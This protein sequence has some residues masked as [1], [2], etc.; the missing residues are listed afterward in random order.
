MLGES[1]RSKSSYGSSRV[2]CQ[3]RSYG[4]TPLWFRLNCRVAEYTGAYD[5]TA[6]KNWNI[7]LGSNQGIATIVF[8]RI[9]SP[10][11]LVSRSGIKYIG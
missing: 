9:S 7:S 3:L 11:L 5:C 2:A 4:G 10:I 8:G 6:N 1:W